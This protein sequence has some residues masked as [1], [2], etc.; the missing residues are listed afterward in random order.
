MHIF[1]YFLNG[2][3]FFRHCQIS[4]VFLFFILAS[5]FVSLYIRDSL[6]WRNQN[7]CRFQAR[8]DI[9]QFTF[10]SKYLIYKGES[11][12]VCMY[13]RRRDIHNLSLQNLAWSPHF[14]RAWHQARG[15]PKIL[16]HSPAHSP[17]HFFSLVP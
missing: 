12:F 14:T 15:Q 10:L 3:I 17:T 4:K 6:E 8:N 7:C 13:V 9:K 1:L 16:A 2:I 5:F 11:M